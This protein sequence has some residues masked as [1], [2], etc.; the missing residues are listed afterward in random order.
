MSLIIYVRIVSTV[1][2]KH[3]K[4]SAPYH[5]TSTL[6]FLFLVHVLK[7]H[8]PTSNNAILW[9]LDSSKLKLTVQFTGALES[10]SAQC[11]PSFRGPESQS[12]LINNRTAEHVEQHG[13]GPSLIREMRASRTEMLD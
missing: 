5:D 1:L 2:E 4:S 11:R 9:I 7:L 8:L 3:D 10:E 6:G 12:P 13:C